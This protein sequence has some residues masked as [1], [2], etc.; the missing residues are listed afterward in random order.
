MAR[1]FLDDVAQDIVDLQA[2]VDANIQTNVTGDIS[3]S[4][5]NSVYTSI[6][7]NMRD[8]LDSS[9]QDEAGLTSSTGLPVA[10]T[11]GTDWT[12]IDDNLAVG[13]YDT[14]IGGDGSFLIPNLAN[15]SIT[16]TSIPG[17]SYTAE[18]A[19]QADLAPGAFVEVALGLNGVPGDL[20]QTINGTSGAR[21]EGAYVRRYL[22][23][24]PAN[25]V[26]QLLL[27]CPDGPETFDIS[28]RTFGVIIM[29]TRN[30]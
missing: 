18:G 8:V 16:G 3:G 26:F 19:I 9:V 2:F 14:A 13:I 4:L 15:G 29:P 20:V 1:R 23:T 22:P 24:T 28:V 25:G 30:P 12:V 11:V 5:V 6:N 7:A 27:R 17:F 10:V 21:F